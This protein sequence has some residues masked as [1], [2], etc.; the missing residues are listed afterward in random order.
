MHKSCSSGYFNAIIFFE[1]GVTDNISN[2]C[3]VINPCD[4]NEGHC[5]YDGQCHGS[6][7]C[8]KNNCPQ[9]SD[10]G[11]NCCY[12]YCGKFLD[13]ENGI[14]DFY[15]PDGNYYKTMDEC[16]WLIQVADNNTISLEFVDVDVSF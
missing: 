2:V 15:L 10:H 12:D 5:H 6:L 14:L 11:T 7:R 8:G 13:M 1:E 16:S 9:N 4:I 3:T